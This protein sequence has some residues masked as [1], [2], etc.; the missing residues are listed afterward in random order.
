MHDLDLTPDEIRAELTDALTE[1]RRH[2]PRLA[3]TGCIPEHGE[4]VDI[5]LDEMASTDAVG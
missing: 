1:W 5:L 4:L 3:R 2:D